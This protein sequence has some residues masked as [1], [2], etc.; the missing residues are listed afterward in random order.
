MTHSPV[1]PARQVEGSAGV[2]LLLQ[3]CMTALARM[4]V[5]EL[6]QDM[7]EMMHTVVHSHEY[8]HVPI[9]YWY[10]AAGGCWSS[11]QEGIMWQPLWMLP[12]LSSPTLIRSSEAHWCC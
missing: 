10:H 12:M 11:T 8:E 5:E 6:P 9:L 7:D 2:G 1:R 3:Q 4:R